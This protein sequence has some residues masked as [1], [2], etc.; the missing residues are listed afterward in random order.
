MTNKVTSKSTRYLWK[1]NCQMV[2]CYIIFGLIGL[3]ISSLYLNWIESDFV[4]INEFLNNKSGMCNFGQISSIIDE[5]WESETKTTELMRFHR[6]A[7]NQWY[8]CESSRI[9]Y[10]NIFLFS[11]IFGAIAQYFCKEN[12]ITMAYLQVSCFFF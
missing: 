1:N 10:F 11:Y 3:V 6:N 5:Y 2:I 8:Y 9:L 12:R 7:M 4:L